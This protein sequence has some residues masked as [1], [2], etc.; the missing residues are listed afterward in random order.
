MKGQTSFMYC[1]PGNFGEWIDS[2]I[3]L[4]AKLATKILGGIF[5]IKL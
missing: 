4:L 5:H 1:T 3:I 2:V